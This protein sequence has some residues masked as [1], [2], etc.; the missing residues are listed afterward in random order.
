MQEGVTGV[1]GIAVQIFFAFPT[2]NFSACLPEISQK[3]QIK[4]SISEMALPHNFSLQ[5]LTIFSSAC[6]LKMGLSHS[7]PEFV[8]HGTNLLEEPRKPRQQ[9]EK[10]K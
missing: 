6:R 7:E 2:D 1:S 10:E 5:H 8:A 9:E 4:P 3:S